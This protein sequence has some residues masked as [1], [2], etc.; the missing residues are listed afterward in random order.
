MVKP[1]ERAAAPPRTARSGSSGRRGYLAGPD[2]DDATGCS[3]RARRTGWTVAYRKNPCGTRR[4]SSPSRD[5]VS[6]SR[7]QWSPTRR[8]PSTVLGVDGRR[9]NDARIVARQTAEGCARAPW[10]QRTSRCTWASRRRNGRV[11]PA[12]GSRGT[13]H[14]GARHAAA[15]GWRCSARQRRDQEP[16]PRDG[17]PARRARVVLDA[18]E[19]A[20][21]RRE[22]GTF[23]VGHIR[24]STV[25]ERVD[26]WPHRCQ[27]STG[28]RRK[29]EGAER[30]GSSWT[31]SVT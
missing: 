3:R 22:C 23:R 9:A 29:K 31:V 30:T 2:R 21:F 6:R 19:I 20:G 18:L 4:S 13:V 17:G 27:R 1:G 11:R 15:R 14:I 8:K 16:D 28:R 25:T 12:D 7:A 26:H 24:D 10:S 5:P